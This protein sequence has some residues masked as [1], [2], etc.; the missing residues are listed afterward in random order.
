MLRLKPSEVQ[1]DLLNRSRQPDRLAKIVAGRGNQTGPEHGRLVDT[2]FKLPLAYEA[3]LCEVWTGTVAVR[4]N[5]VHW[6][7]CATK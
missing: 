4:S 2:S 3:P 1:L 5:Y 7:L 6:L